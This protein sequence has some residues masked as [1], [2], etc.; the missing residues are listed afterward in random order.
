MCLLPFF[1]HTA[2]FRL[3]LAVSAI[4]KKFGDEPDRPVVLLCAT[5]RLALTCTTTLE[6]AGWAC[7]RIPC[8][9]YV[10]RAARVL[11]ARAL[12]SDR[13]TLASTKPFG[14]VQGTLPIVF[15]GRP[16]REAGAR[17][18][19]ATLFLPIPIDTAA[20]V[21]GL[22]R[23]KQNP[24]SQ[25]LEAG[26]DPNGLWLDPVTVW[27]RVGTTPLALSRRHFFVLYELV[28]NPGKL[29]TTERLCSSLANIEPMPRGALMTCIWRL[30]KIL[31]AAGAPDCI[32]TVHHLGYR[33]AISTS[34]AARL[35]RAPLATLSFPKNSQTG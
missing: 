17:Q 8:L 35:S 25:Q 14:T 19:G 11:E 23:M 30:R 26:A 27:A 12:I 7:H 5:N 15:M 24:I 32:E 33:Y 10:D 2:I 21:E 3:K 18:A 29:L 28:S 34:Q 1:L 9:R 6:G 20:L 16:G 22:S 4:R 31:R 13:M